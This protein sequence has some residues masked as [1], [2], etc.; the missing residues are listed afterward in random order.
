MGETK[1]AL[2][3]GKSALDVLLQEVSGWQQHRSGAGAW[4]GAC[5]AGDSEVTIAHAIPQPPRALPRRCG[6]G[7]S[8]FCCAVSSPC[9]GHPERVTLNPRA[10][11]GGPASG[12]RRS[13]QKGLTAAAAASAGAGSERRRPGATGEGRGGAGSVVRSG[14]RGG[15][16]ERAG[17]RRGRGR[18][19]AFWWVRPVA[20]GARGGRPE[21]RPSGA[22]GCP[23]PRRRP[24]QPRRYR[25]FLERLVSDPR[26]ARAGRGRG[27]GCAKA[28]H[29]G[30]RGAVWRQGPP[31]RGADSAAQV[32]DAER[33]PGCSGCCGTSVLGGFQRLNMAWSKP[34]VLALQGLD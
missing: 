11:S 33:A 23:S 3:P 29:G 17:S 27:G 22:L 31:P 24:Q 4:L 9:R 34:V 20:R 8:G 5:S 7:A 30:V 25:G 10:G 32:R 12:E 18:E 13:R 21:R 15:G 16:R 14:G 26:A 2:S 28:L 6:P 19:E 1:P